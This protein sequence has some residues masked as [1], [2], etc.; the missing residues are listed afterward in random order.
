MNP[1]VVYGIVMAVAS[2]F[3]TLVLYFLGLHSDAAKMTQAQ[4][5]G[6]LGA[7]V[8]NVVCVVLGIRAQRAETPAGKNFGYGR[9]LG[10]GVLISVVAGLI[11]IGTSW[12]YFGTI[13]P[14][15]RDLLVQ[16]QLDKMAA[17]GLSSDQLDR[18]EKGI[19]FFMQ[20]VIMGVVTFINAVVWGTLISLVAAGFLKRRPGGA[21][22]AEPPPVG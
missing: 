2:A 19:R 15:F 9:A 18:A 16:A 6:G 20:P 4:W 17:A 21:P 7:F 12:F 3:L 8:I 22:L 10:V 11:G 14:G 5:V 1:P 13:N